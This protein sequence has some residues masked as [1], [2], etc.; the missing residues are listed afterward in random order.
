MTS[1]HYIRYFLLKCCH[2]NTALVSQ[3]ELLQISC[4]LLRDCLY[5]ANYPCVRACNGPCQPNTPNPG[6]PPPPDASE[7]EV[8]TNRELVKSSFWLFL[9]QFHDLNEGFTQ[10]GSA[11]RTQFKTG[12]LFV[13]CNYCYEGLQRCD[14]PMYVAIVIVQRCLI[15][16]FPL[17]AGNNTSA[18][19]RLG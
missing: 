13:S 3:K 1:G 7:K 4:H 11:I 12:V 10:E 14:Q 19:S 17:S 16:L 6:T 5:C 15:F 9:H 2:S 8:L 18:C